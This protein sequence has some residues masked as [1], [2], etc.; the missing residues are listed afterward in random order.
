LIDGLP[1]FSPSLYEFVL[2]YEFLHNS[3]YIP[4]SQSSIQNSGTNVAWVS[5]L[6]PGPNHK[7]DLCITDDTHL[8]PTRFLKRV[9]TYLFF[10]H[11]DA[12]VLMTSPLMLGPSPNDCCDSHFN[13]TKSS[14]S[15]FCDYC[16]VTSFVCHQK[17]IWQYISAKYFD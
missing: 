12:P 13:S 8:L 16:A 3:H 9:M 11:L 4:V 14:S 1:C 10:H 6:L 7:P 17:A 2:C 5:D 15:P